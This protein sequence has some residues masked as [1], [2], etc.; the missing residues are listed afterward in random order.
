MGKI[1]R[2]IQAKYSSIFRGVPNVFFL[3]GEGRGG[4]GAR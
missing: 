4:G 3:G 2:V 1:L